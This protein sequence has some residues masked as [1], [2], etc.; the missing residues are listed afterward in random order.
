[1]KGRSDIKFTIDNLSAAL[2]LLNKQELSIEL[3]II[4]NENK[5]KLSELNSFS[6]IL[7]KSIQLAKK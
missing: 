4:L 1:M 7:L 2:E 3:K 5:Y 6:E